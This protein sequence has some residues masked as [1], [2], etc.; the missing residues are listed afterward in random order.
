[1]LVYVAKSALA[2]LAVDAVVNPTNSLCVFS[3]Q[4]GE[5]LRAAGGEEVEREAQALAPIAVGAAGV[6]TGGELW[7]RHVIHVPTVEEPGMK[8]GVEN[9]RRATR[10]ALIA[11]ERY[12][13][14]TLG[15]PPFGIEP[16][17]V[18]LDEAARAVA[19]ELKAHRQLFPQTVYLVAPTEEL[20]NVFIEALRNLTSLG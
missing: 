19:D 7:A 17:E 2:D 4:I 20:A 6:T 15:L 8:A 1:M 3:N 13:F 10:A 5:S 14:S 9:V 11:A 18:P 12:H 16:G